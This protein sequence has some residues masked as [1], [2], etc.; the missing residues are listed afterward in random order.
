MRT[1]DNKLR[2]GISAC[3]LGQRVRY[4]GGHKRDALLLKAFGR[5]VEWVP[6]C[7]EVECGLP[8]PREPMHLEGDADAPR[9]VTNDTGVDHTDRLLR[10]A[11][12][13]VGQ[14]DA[15]GVCGFVLKSGSPSCGLADAA[16]CG[17]GLFAR[18]L[19]RRLPLVP[20]RE[21]EQLREP[22][23]LESFLSCARAAGPGRPGGST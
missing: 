6:V 2:L 11:R 13:R 15:E 7:P 17:A 19:V 16:P 5:R 14:L 3:L 20:V 4:D 12:R 9:L 18:E 23:A 1:S 8:V 21:A 22:A 10:W